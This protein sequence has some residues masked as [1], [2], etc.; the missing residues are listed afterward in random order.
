MGFFWGGFFWVGFLMP[1]LAHRTS[2][3]SLFHSLKKLEFYYVWDS[4]YGRPH[5]EHTILWYS[6]EEKI[7]YAQ[8]SNSGRPRLG[9]V[10]YHW[11]IEA[12]LLKCHQAGNG[13]KITAGGNKIRQ[14]NKIVRH[15]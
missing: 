10:F 1:T 15:E 8:E 12:D 3:A 5:D 11:T 7:Y 9:R 14:T 2:A 6:A 4:K 13:V